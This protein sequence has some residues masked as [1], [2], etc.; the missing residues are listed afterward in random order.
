MRSNERILIPKANLRDIGGIQAC[1]GNKVQTG[2]IYRSGHLSDLTELDLEFLRSLQL[3]TIIDL[4][5]PKETQERP[6]P[7][8]QGCSIN[9]ISVSSSDNEFA[10]VAGSLNNPD[11]A[12]QAS[13]MID[14]YFGGIVTDRLH[15][16]R[17]VFELAVNP[18]NYPLLFNCTAGKDR[19]GFVAA[20][21]L[22]LLGVS[23]DEVVE[24]FLLSNEVRKNQIESH[25]DSYRKSLAE[26]QDCLES[27]IE[28]HLLDPL[29]ALVMTKPSYMQ[30]V[31]SAI[32]SEWGSWEIFRRDGLKISDSDFHN[33]QN[34]MIK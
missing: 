19:T 3:K 22:G 7:F 4:R 29:R 5:R 6:H 10:V 12:K 2:H 13:G 34:F 8:L 20:I 9:E 33:F 1:D 31:F 14:K 15:L 18:N 25:L 11:I 27:E 26:Q 28:D 16:Y 21:L 17:P 23:E 24:D 30:S 32:K